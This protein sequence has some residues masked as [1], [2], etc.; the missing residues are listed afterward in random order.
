MPGLLRAAELDRAEI[1]RL[2]AAARRLSGGDAAESLATAKPYAGRPSKVLALLFAEDSLRTRVRFEAAAARLGVATTSVS[3]AKQSAQMAVPESLE[4]TIRCLD[5]CCDAICLR[6]PDPDAPEVAAGVATSPVINCGNGCEE[7]PPQALVDLL[8]ID[9]LRGGIDGTR[10]AMV[11]DLRHMRCAHSLLAMLSRFEGV[12]VRCISPTRLAM[13][14]RFAAGFERAAGESSKA[15]GRPAAAAARPTAADPPARPAS[16]ILFADELD[17]DGVEVIYVAG[18][19]STKENG[20]TRSEQRRLRIDRALLQG[21][22]PAVKVLC[23]LPRVDEISP[24]VDEMPQA[25]YF[26]QNALG[27]PMKTALLRWALDGRCEPAPS[28]RSRPPAA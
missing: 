21:L 13:P 1:E 14:D 20:V 23:P 17:L 5:A 25:A 16:T 22:D 3:A 9:C 12:H 4:D 10:I 18:L 26:R 8:T 24:E 19:P 2:I 27:L 7:H 6:H 15:T 28:R 11:G